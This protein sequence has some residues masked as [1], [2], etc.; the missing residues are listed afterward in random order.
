MII[1][2]RLKAILESEIAMR[3]SIEGTHPNAFV[4]TPVFISMKMPFKRRYVDLPDGVSY[5][6]NHDFHHP[7]GCA[8]QDE[9]T[10]HIIRAPFGAEA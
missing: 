2:E 9:T 7:L 10:G 5:F 3:N 8:Y 4:S 1:S 6:T